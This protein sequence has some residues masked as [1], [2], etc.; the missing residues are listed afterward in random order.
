M[1]IEISLTLIILYIL[2]NN[3]K[4]SV[5]ESFEQV[6]DYKLED[7][8]KVDPFFYIKTEYVPTDTSMYAK[9]IQ[10]NTQCYNSKHC[11]I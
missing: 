11:Q 10:L 6:H 4:L 7:C 1:I 8:Q 5:K 9:N 3:T 2:F